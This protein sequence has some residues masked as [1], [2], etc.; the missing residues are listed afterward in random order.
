MRRRLVLAVLLSVVTVVVPSSC[1]RAKGSREAG[2]PPAFTLEVAPAA[3]APAASR[4]DAVVPI[5]VADSP[6]SPPGGSC[7]TSC[8]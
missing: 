6:S 8:G 4:D 5:G 3:K 1:L 2:P 7:S